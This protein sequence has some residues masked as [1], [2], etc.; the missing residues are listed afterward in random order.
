MT[1]GGASHGGVPWPARRRGSTEQAARQHCA[2]V[3]RGCG[4]KGKLG[5]KA[6]MAG[7]GAARRKQWGGPAAGRA[8]LRSARPGIAAV[9]RGTTLR[10][11]SAIDRV[12]ITSHGRSSVL[13][14]TETTAIN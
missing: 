6:A 8:G 14:R 4:G 2:G 12:A 5:R 9:L 7:G 1:A 13:P 10:A 11:A 3:A